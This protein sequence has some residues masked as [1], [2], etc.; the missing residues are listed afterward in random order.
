[1][2]DGKC[3]HDFKLGGVVSHPADQCPF[4]VVGIRMTTVEI[5]GDWSGGTHKVNQRSWVNH[6]EIKHYKSNKEEQR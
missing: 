2:K 6:T 4:E 3:L 1:M 5:R